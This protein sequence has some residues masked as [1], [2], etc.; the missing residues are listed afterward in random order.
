MDTWWCYHA[1]EP[2]AHAEGRRPAVTDQEPNECDQVQCLQDA[3]PQRQGL[4]GCFGWRAGRRGDD[5]K[6][7]WDFFQRWCKCSD[8]S[9]VAVH[10]TFPPAVCTGSN[11]SIFSV[12]LVIYRLEFSRPGGSEVVSCDLHFPEDSM[13]SCACCLCTF[14]GEISSQILCPLLNDVICLAE[15]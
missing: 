8:S 3:H 14:F 2:W 7:G 5:S 15:L 4:H 12:T 6:R 9:G 1:D 10:V 11:L 13:F